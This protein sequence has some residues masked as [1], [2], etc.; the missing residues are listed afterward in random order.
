[1]P[2]SGNE[3]QTFEVPTDGSEQEISLGTR[4]TRLAHAAWKDGALHFSYQVNLP[5]SE[6]LSF[7]E[8]WSVSDDRQTLTVE[9]SRDGGRPRTLVFLRVVEPEPHEA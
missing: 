7:T 8:I 6:S 4:M 9:R 1:L 2:G 3:T 5:E